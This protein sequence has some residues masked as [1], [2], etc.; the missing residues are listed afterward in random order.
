MSYF[1]GAYA[2]SPTGELWNSELEAEYYSK[3]KEQANIK[4]LEHPFLGTLHPYDDTWFLN[5]IDPTWTFVFTCIPGTMNELEKNPEF[6]LASTSESG[7]LAALA[8]LE[9][10]R[11]SIKQLNSHLGRQAVAAIQIH[12]AP[13][14]P[15]GTSSKTAFQT[16]LETLLEW[17]WDGTKVVIEHCDT[18]LDEHPPAK[19]FLSLTEEADAIIAANNNA[20]H[21]A[22]MV[23]N[24]GRSVIETRH[25]EGA[26]HHI[27]YL[28]Q[29]GLLS[30][31]MFSG[32]SDKASEFGAWQDT[33]MPPTAR[34]EHDKGE[35][36]SLMSAVEIHKCLQ[37]ANAKE[38]KELILG[39]KL[40]IRPN[41]ASIGDR[42]A[43]NANALSILDDFF[44]N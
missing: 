31:V 22:G 30:G 8:F 24:W 39:I 17:D 10:A 1:V 44:I 32:V 20:K 42:I 13:K 26:I 40:G 15:T 27:N 34:T 14:Q 37:A 12:S 43:Y 29:H 35:P 33:H 4:G 41:T 11:L 18:L 9:K 3:L 5:N 7:R 28:K 36:N 25:P 2:S 23:I 16:S 21:C 6:G 19:G 38:N